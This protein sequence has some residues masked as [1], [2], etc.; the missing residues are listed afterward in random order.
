[1]RKKINVKLN[2]IFLDN[3]SDFKDDIIDYEF[4][5][6]KHPITKMY[7]D[8]IEKLNNVDNFVDFD[9]KGEKIFETKEK[10][11]EVNPVPPDN[12]SI[13][14]I[15]LNKDEELLDQW[16]VPERIMGFHAINSGVFEIKD[17]DMLSKKHRVGI[18]VD[19]ELFNEE[20]TKN[21]L[22]QR[23][24]NSNEFDMDFI[25]AYFNTLTHELAHCKE[26]IENTNGMTPYE[27][28]NL[29]EEEMVDLTFYDISNGHGIL[30][31]F[32]ENNDRYELDEIMEERVEAKGMSWIHK[33]KLNEM[34]IDSLIKSVNIDEKKNKIKFKL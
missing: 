21:R 30:F 31:D 20:F 11:K 14:I 15:F 24:I 17:N 9:F 23:D 8:V 4:K 22:F 7:L 25:Y 6:K 13:D 10:F 5:L 26:F 1:M 3:D 18:V 2:P 12:I 19:P 29:Q 28:A 27:V 33:I 34:L 32:D 16:C